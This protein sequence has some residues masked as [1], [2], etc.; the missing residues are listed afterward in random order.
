ML[1]TWLRFCALKKRQLFLSF[2]KRFAMK[3]WILSAAFI[4]ALNSYVAAQSNASKQS[5]PAKA[6]KKGTETKKDTDTKSTVT[7]QADTSSHNAKIKLP[8]FPIDTVNVPAA[9]KE[10]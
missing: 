2:L 1:K 7:V 10:Q 8:A 4:I 3:K 5:K 9:K 6:V